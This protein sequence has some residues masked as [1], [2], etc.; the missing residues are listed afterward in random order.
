MSSWELFDSFRRQFAYDEWANREV[1][2]AIRA[3]LDAAE[4]PLQLMALIAEQIARAMRE[5]GQTPAYTDL[6]ARCAGN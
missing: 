4:R 6:F 1:V 5:S 3:S 2:T